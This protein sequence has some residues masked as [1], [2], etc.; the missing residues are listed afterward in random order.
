MGGI[1]HQE[2]VLEDSSL[3]LSGQ[4]TVG[5]M[6]GWY[7]IGWGKEHLHIDSGVVASRGR[8]LISHIEKKGNP[9]LDVS[10]DS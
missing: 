1:P 6:A 5:R 4:H 2:T 7:A 10:E 9:V 8:S 3:F